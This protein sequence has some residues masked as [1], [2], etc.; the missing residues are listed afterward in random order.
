MEGQGYEQNYQGLIKELKGCD[1]QESAKRLGLKALENGAEASF[2]GRDFIITEDG[3]VAKDGLDSNPNYRSILIHYVLSKGE[4]EPGEEFLSLFQLPGV[5]RSRRQQNWKT[6]LDGPLFEAFGD[7]HH[8]FAP[9]AEAL[10]GSYLGHHEA[11]GH[12]WE[13]QV[14]PKIRMRLVFEEADDEF[15]MQ[16]RSMFDSRATDFLGF[17]CLAFLHGCLVHALTHSPGGS[18]DQATKI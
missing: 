10:G 4:G 12:L 16:V 7:G 6:L 3:V 17:E 1:F 15:P 11:G 5:L 18:S 9:A 14:L 13:F 8:K 2:M